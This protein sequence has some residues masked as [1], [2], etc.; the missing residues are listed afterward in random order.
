MFKD[1]LHWFPS[2]LFS[3]LLAVLF[4][5]S[6]IVDYLVPKITA[7]KAGARPGSRQDRSSFLVIQ[8]A[9]VLAVAVAFAGRY[10]N[11]IVLPSSVQWLGLAVD[12]FGI[13]FREWAVVTLGRFFSRIVE[14]EPGHRLIRE[15]PYRRIRHPAYTGMILIYVGLALAMG[16]GAGTLAATLLIGGATLYRIK[17]EEAALARVFGTQYEDYVRQTWRLFPAW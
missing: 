6:Y 3:T 15:G 14:I 12:V 16:S 8:G 2:P 1:P 11:W 4:F 5:G 13:A 7:P 9:G 10:L 17:V